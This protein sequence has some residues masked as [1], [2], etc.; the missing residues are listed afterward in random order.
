[1]KNRYLYFIYSFILLLVF[2][3]C[4]DMNELHEEWMKDG[5]INYIGKVDSAHVTSGDQRI[6]FDCYLSDKRVKYLNI[7][8]VEFGMNRETRIA[9]E[10]VVPGSPFSFILEDD[11]AVAEGDFT[12]TFISDDNAGTYSI[13]F[14]TVGKV[15]GEKYAGSLTNRTLLGFELV[16]EGIYMQFSAPLNETDQGLEVYYNNGTE[17]VTLSFTVEELEEP[18]FISTPNFD[19]P[20]Q[21]STLYQPVNCMDTFRAPTVTP[22]IEKYVNVALNKPAT[23]SPTLNDSYTA[24]KAVD[25][26]IGDNASRWINARVAGGHW[27][28]IDLEEEH[29]VEQVKIYD[30]TPITNFKLEVFQE[31][32]WVLLDDV[33]DGSNNWTGLYESIPASKIRYVFE[34]VA[35]N[36]ETDPEYSSTII[37]MFEMEVFIKTKI[38]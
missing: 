15:Y 14:N 31:G 5:E 32:E 7:N 28:E 9:V 16:E 24:D 34:T 11:Q 23:S 30:D 6:G 18:V 1:M 3:S 17:D 19:T 10:E 37:R 29:A 20:L 13:D 21:Y 22:T 38:Q 33:T 12:F 27:L 8:W 25:G 35:D 4:E 26:I 2:A 36:P